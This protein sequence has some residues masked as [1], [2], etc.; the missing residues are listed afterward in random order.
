MLT[1]PTCVRIIRQWKKSKTPSVALRV[2][3][4]PRESQVRCLGLACEE[5]DAGILFIV[6]VRAGTLGQ[7]KRSMRLVWLLLY[8]SGLAQLGN[9][10]EGTC[11]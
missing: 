10:P 7:D 1:L 8:Y 9:T 4:R 2:V 6:N 3:W 5:Y 11:D